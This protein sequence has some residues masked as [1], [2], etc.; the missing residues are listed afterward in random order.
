MKHR[1]TPF[2]DYPFNLD[3]PLSGQAMRAYREKVIEPL[4]DIIL[5][6]QERLQGKYDDFCQYFKNLLESGMTMDELMLRIPGMAINE[7]TNKEIS[8]ARTR[9]AR[10]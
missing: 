2:S 10:D 5:A 4:Q 8:D 1:I 7:L 6:D 9:K 3:E